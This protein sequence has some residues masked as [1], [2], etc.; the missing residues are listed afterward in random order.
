MHDR[1]VGPVGA[2]MDRRRQ[3]RPSL[4]RAVVQHQRRRDVVPPRLAEGALLLHLQGFARY[5]ASA[6][7][8]RLQILEYGAITG[9]QIMAANSLV[10]RR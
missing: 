4:Q 2:A 9:I 3:P 8:L 1:L 5:Q 7:P 6:R 10:F